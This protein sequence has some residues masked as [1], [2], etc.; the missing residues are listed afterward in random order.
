[1]YI[2]ERDVETKTKVDI[3]EQYKT[4]RKGVTNIVQQELYQATSTTSQ[5]TIS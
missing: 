5:D 4:E 1:M 3:R 2:T